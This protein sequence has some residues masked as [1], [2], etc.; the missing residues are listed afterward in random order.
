[1]YSISWQWQY[2][3]TMMAAAATYMFTHMYSNVVSHAYE[4]LPGQGCC[5]AEHMRVAMQC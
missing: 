1:M 2:S 3:S 5:S 4:H